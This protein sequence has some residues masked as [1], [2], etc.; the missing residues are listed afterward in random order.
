MK[1]I[2]PCPSCDALCEAK[3]EVFAEIAQRARIP[4]ERMVAIG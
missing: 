1:M 3:V 4:I 2:H